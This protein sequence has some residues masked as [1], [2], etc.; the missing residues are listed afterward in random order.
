MRGR[1]TSVG[2]VVRSQVMRFLLCYEG[3]QPYIQRYEVRFL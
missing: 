3:A 1:Q 2:D